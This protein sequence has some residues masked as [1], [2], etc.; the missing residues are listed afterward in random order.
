MEPNEDN[1]V[2]GPDE[3]DFDENMMET[4]FELSAYVA[5]NDENDDNNEDGS[6]DDENNANTARRNQ[7][8][9]WTYR[10]RPR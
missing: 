10:Y 7:Q 9:G 6:D 5:T 4:M 1:Y 8:T 2:D 3:D